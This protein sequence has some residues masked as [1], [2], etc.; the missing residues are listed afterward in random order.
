MEQCVL[1]PGI[2]QWIPVGWIVGT[3]QNILVRSV[4]ELH[5]AKSL[6]KYMARGHLPFLPGFLVVCV[7]WM[8]PLKDQLGYRTPFLLLP[9]L[10]LLYMNPYPS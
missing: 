2:P 3:P 8:L 5:S 9:S 7:E 1:L 4:W 10:G 6:E